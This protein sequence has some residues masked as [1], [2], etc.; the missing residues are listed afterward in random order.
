MSTNEDIFEGNKFSKRL[1]EERQRL[2]MT[3]EEFG[4]AAGVRRA[5]QYLYERAERTPSVE[6]L[7]RITSVGADLSYLISGV[8]SPKTGGKLCLDPEVLASVLRTADDIC[9]DH[10]G[11]LLDLEH[12]ITLTQALCRAVAD[13]EP[14]EVDWQDLRLRVANSD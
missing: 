3:Q 9:R 11:R 13:K 7:A 10:R 6:Y 2:S 12:R 5:T 1:K 4:A 8:R 14:D